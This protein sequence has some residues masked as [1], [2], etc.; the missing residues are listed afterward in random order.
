MIVGTRLAVEPGRGKRAVPVRSAFI[1]AI[2]G[3]LGVVACLTIGRGLTSTVGDPARAG[4]TWE[5]EALTEGELTPND[6][7]AIVADDD[8]TDAMLAT[9]VRAVEMDGRSVPAFG[10]RQ[11]VGDVDFVVLDGR[12]PVAPDEVAMAP[13]TMDQLGL[14]VGDEIGLGPGSA[15]RGGGR[16]PRAPSGDVAH[17]L[18][19]ERLDDGG[20]SGSHRAPR[21][22]RVTSVSA[23]SCSASGRELI[24]T[25]RSS[26][27]GHWTSTTWSHP[28]CHLPSKV[29]ATYAACPSPWPC[30]SP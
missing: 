28:H 5:L 9:W 3:V 6:V 25:P 7:D 2:V 27:C 21:A 12:A 29:S 4:V 1:G 11:L 18:R 26:A 30:S 8:V 19:P 10:T 24:S 17:Q 20:G 22:R 15:V 14:R 16:R 13:V 23:A